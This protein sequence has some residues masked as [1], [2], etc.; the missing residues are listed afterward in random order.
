MAKTIRICWTDGIFM[1]A[2]FAAA[3]AFFPPE[4]AAGQFGARSLAGWFSVTSENGW[5]G[6][7]Y[8]D[9][10][11][12]FAE[13]FDSDGDGKIDVWRFYRRGVLSSQERDLNGDGKIDYVARWDS[14]SQM[15]VSMA[16]DTSFRGM[17]NLEMDVLPSGE[18]QIRED[19]NGDGVAD[20]ILVAAGPYEFFSGLALDLSVRDNAIGGV[21][22]EYWV[23]YSADDGFT[24]TV[25]D[26]RR[27]QRGVQTH[28]GV[29]EESRVV[30]RRYDGATPP[31]QVAYAPAPTQPAAPGPPRADPALGG[32]QPRYDPNAPQQSYDPFVDAAPGQLTRD[33]TRYEGMPPGESAARSLP[34]RMRPPGVGR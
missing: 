3:L 11:T 26:F 34:A 17:N 5:Q 30:W 6:R 29:W 16:R 9:G 23:E 21:P 4:A 10:N 27:Y 31:P 7:R 20:R 2:A 32:G 28:Y 33:R 12:V 15:L 24:G 25:T 19:R 1:A 14:P 13:E 22:S 18:W 8:V